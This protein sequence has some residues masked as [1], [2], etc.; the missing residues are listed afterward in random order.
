MSD[1]YFEILTPLGIRVRTTTSYWARIV[2]FKH[3]IMRG[4]EALVQKALREPAQVRRSKRDAMVQLYYVPEP[5]YHVCVVVKCHNGEGFII[6]AYRT[7][8]IKEG[9]RLWPR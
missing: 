4:K 8:T 6:T 3:P 5:P 7:D 9:E 2:T 1:T